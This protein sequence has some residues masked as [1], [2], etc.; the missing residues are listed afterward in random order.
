[1]NAPTPAEAAA[2]L[3]PLSDDQC[4]RVGALLSLAPSKPEAVAS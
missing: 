2:A 4:R 3:G 1:M